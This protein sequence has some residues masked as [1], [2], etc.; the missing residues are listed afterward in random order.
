MTG[1]ELFS[2]CLISQRE[3][4]S[5]TKIDR[6][7][8]VWSIWSGRSVID[9]LIMK[10]AIRISAFDDENCGQNEEEEEEDDDDDDD[11]DDDNDYTI[12]KLG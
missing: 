5:L 2:H 6:L 4:R 8:N 1:E 12:I 10:W 11:N 9:W 3:V 7:Y